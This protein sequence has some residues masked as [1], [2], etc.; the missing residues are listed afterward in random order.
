MKK[1]DESHY[2]GEKACQGTVVARECNSAALEAATH[3]A[4]SPVTTI[5]HTTLPSLQTVIDDKLR[6]N[7]AGKWKSEENA[8]AS[9]LHR[10]ARPQCIR[11]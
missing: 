10:G 11:R 1:A 9:S 7:R 5:R 6:E 2:G 4:F 8:D 3:R